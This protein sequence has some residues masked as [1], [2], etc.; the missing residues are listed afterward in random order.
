MAQPDR[1]PVSEPRPVV[2]VLSEW[3]HSG[4]QNIWGPFPDEPAARGAEALLTE[5]GLRG[6]WHVYPLLPV[7]VTGATS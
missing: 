5:Y 7:V 2:L 4:V 1:G 6:W 3:D